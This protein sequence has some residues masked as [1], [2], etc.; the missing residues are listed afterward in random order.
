MRAETARILATALVS[1]LVSLG[2]Y[3]LWLNVDTEDH[4]FEP[5]G[6][7]VAHVHL[8]WGWVVWS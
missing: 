5:C 4:G 3:V 6:N 1:V 2:A 7:F 8:P